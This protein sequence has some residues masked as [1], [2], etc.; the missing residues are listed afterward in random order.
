MGCDC[1]P[2]LDSFGHIMFEQGSVEFGGINQIISFRGTWNHGIEPSTFILQIA[3]QSAY[4]IPLYGTLIL[5]Y[6]DTKTEIKD[7]IVDKGSATFDESGHVVSLFIRDYRWKWSFETVYGTYNVRDER[8]DI[9]DVAGYTGSGLDE[10]IANTKRPTAWLVDYLLDRLKVTQKRV[11][12]GS[13]ETF[14]ECIWDGENAAL[15]L[16]QICSKL[17]LVII[18]MFN[19]G[20]DVKQSWLLAMPNLPEQGLKSYSQTLDRKERPKY[21]LAISQPALFTVDFLL[22][23]VI[24]TSSR[25][26]RFIVDGDKHDYRKRGVQS[27]FAGEGLKEAERQRWE[28]S[29]FRWYRVVEGTRFGDRTKNLGLPTLKGPF[30]TVLDYNDDLL[31]LRHLTSVTQ[32]QASFLSQFEIQDFCC[33]RTSADNLDPDFAKS[34]PFKSAFVWGAFYHDSDGLQRDADFIGVNSAYSLSKIKDPEALSYIFE[35]DET[36]KNLRYICPVPF[37]LDKK[38]GIVKFQRPVYLK[39]DNNSIE[40]PELVLRC[41]IKAKYINTGSFVDMFEQNTCDP[42][43]PARIYRETFGIT[44]YL[45]IDRSRSNRDD[46]RKFLKESA[47]SLSNEFTWTEDAGEYEYSIWFPIELSTMIRS[48]SWSLDQSG[49]KMMV[50]VGS[51]NGSQTSRSYEQRQRAVEFNRHQEFVAREDVKQRRRALGLD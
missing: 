9:L 10:C 47:E 39:G 27:G 45:E 3:P 22:R 29:V 41:A 15:A 33:E 13:N 5:R 17:G 25:E 19:G 20:V 21:V 51:D 31:E 37:E 2:H 1:S 28:E 50:S 35:D 49:A 4:T 24:L 38:R 46:V 8:G 14:P 18:P 40:W 32:H 16:E 42:D 43:S 7:C 44:P 26:V 23:P 12:V 11:N 36:N 34:A 30:A 48:I 6:G